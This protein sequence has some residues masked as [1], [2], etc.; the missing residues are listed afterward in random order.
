MS[1]ETTSTGGWTSADAA[2]S[3]P[4]NQ[5]PG[6]TDRVAFCQ[7]CGKPLTAETV[8]PVGTGVFCEPCLTARV[9]GAS[10]AP[11]YAAPPYTTVPPYGTVPSQAAVLNE[12]SPG[13]AGFLGFIF[14][15]AGAAYNG[16]YA[17]GLVHLA[18]FAV[19]VAFSDNINGIFGIFVAG[20]VCYMS[21]EAYHTAKARRD[22][23]PLPNPFGLNDIGERMGFGKNWGTV[24]AT[25]ATAAAPATPPPAATPGYAPNINAAPE[26]VPVGTT[27][28]WV[29]YVPPTAFG[30]AAAQQEAA[31][32]QAAQT[33]T[34]YSQNTYAPYNPTPHSPSPYAQTYTGPGY[35]TPP[36]TGLPVAALAPDV[37]STR[38]P[39]GAFWLIGIGLLILL[40][41]LIPDWHM[42]DRWFW[43][44]LFAGL[45]AWLFSRRMHSGV[46]LICIIRWPV[47]LMTLAI[48]FALHA[49]YLP[50]TFG[51]TV[52]VLLIVFGALLL[53]ERTAGATPVYEPPVSYSVVPNSAP[54]ETEADLP[55][56][57]FTDNDSDTTKG[58][59]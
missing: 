50:V 35:A 27:P 56:A 55:R 40:A 20:W 54:A 12:P 8:R 3:T 32:V 57:A 39:V 34:Y 58:G 9:A 2:G 15:G 49:A 37:P 6:A 17:K 42:N 13:L 31:R 4:P 10:A 18:I 25:A 24:G 28:D 14:P 38:F 53:L 44:I 21:F 48:L 41:N 23:L 1:D 26:Y 30:A 51:L 19:L 46:K 36:P 47:I 29:G 43:P 22:G 7:D 16:Q 45:S 33:A 5:A 59:Q 11:G 52:S